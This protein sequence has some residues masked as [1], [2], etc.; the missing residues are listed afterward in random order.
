MRVD[1]RARASKMRV[2]RRKREEKGA[3]KFLYSRS[4]RKGYWTWF[5]FARPPPLPPP[6][7]GDRGD[8]RS[9]RVT[10]ERRA[11]LQARATIYNAAIDEAIILRANE[12]YCQRD[13]DKNGRANHEIPRRLRSPAR[14]SA[15]FRKWK[16]SRRP[17]DRTTVRCA[18]QFDR[19]VRESRGVPLRYPLHPPRSRARPMRTLINSHTPRVS[20]V[21][22]RC[23]NCERLSS[24]RIR[25]RMRR[26]RTR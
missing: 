8:R 19:N 4:L 3:R 23:A 9:L 11:G 16:K 17:I 12:H 20:R 6:R 1:P 10:K 15:R 18:I 2:E 26:K 21:P 24:S 14:T 22:W 25:R 13:V 5:S 7:T